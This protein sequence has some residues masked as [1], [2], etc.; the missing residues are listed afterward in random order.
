[1]MNNNEQPSTEQP[2]RKPGRPK[3]ALSKTKLLILR[4]GATLFM[5][6]GYDKVSLE[7]VAKA[8]GITK[9][10]VYYYFNNK[11][12]LFTA[13]LVTVMNIAH[14][15]TEQILAEPLTLKE[16]LYKIAFKQMSNANLDFESMMRDA[17][18]ELSKE[19][20]ALIRSAEKQ[21]SDIMLNAFKQSIESGEITSSHQPVMLA[22]AFIALLTMKN[23]LNLRQQDMPLEQLVE[24]I[25]EIVWVGIQKEGQP[26]VSKE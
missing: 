17:S 9:A 16:K 20:S 23:H 8:C 22:H 18:I 2:K 25:I 3:A 7:S 10:S 19:Q 21:L 6:V 24:E 1:M 14:K 12:E 15:A 11:S 13:C 4:T 5:E 26:E